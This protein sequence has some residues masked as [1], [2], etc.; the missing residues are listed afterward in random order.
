M[1]NLL[2]KMPNYAPDGPLGTE[3]KGQPCHYHLTLDSQLILEILGLLSP[4]G[5]AVGQVLDKGLKPIGH[6]T[7]QVGEPA[8]EALQNVEKQVMKEKGYKDEIDHN[9]PDSELPGGERIGGNTQTGQN[10]LGL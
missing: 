7:K 2:N 4:A 3:K 5:D 6:F 10:P 1:E 8:G 9:K